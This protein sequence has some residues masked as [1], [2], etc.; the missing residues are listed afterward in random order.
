MAVRIDG[1]W[2]DV[3]AIMLAEGHAL[4]LP[5]RTEWAWN[6]GYSAHRRAGGRRRARA[7]EPGVLRGRARAT[8]RRCA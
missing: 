6:A 8:P 5:N 3:G 7:L 2:R 4:W 1:R